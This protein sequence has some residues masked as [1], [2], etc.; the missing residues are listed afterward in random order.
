M[1]F[2]FSGVNLCREKTRIPSQ[3]RDPAQAGLSGP[4]VF[5]AL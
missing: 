4:G 2:A 1:R 3:H 5:C